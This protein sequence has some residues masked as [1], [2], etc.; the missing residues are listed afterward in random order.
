VGTTSFILPLSF[1]FFERAHIFLYVRHRGTL[2]TS[3]PN[4]ATSSRCA[5]CSSSS[6]RPCADIFHRGR[7]FPCSPCM[8]PFCPRNRHGRQHL[9]VQPHRRRASLW[10]SW[11]TQCASYSK[12]R[13]TL[14][15]D[16]IPVSTSPWP[17][18]P[19]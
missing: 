15:W 16:R 14:S 3:P 11:L 1:F 9:S 5:N 2:A 4:C 17:L 18:S 12:Y 13:S 10:P 6:S 8:L 19:G 7:H